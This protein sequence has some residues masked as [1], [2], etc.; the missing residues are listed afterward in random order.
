[1]L[2]LAAEMLCY[3]IRSHCLN[4][5]DIPKTQG[6]YNVKLYSESL[7]RT[8][9]VTWKLLNENKYQFSLCIPS[10]ILDPTRPLWCA[11]KRNWKRGRINH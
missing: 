7:D 5:Q 6:I 4:R 2:M 11:I 8:K 1:M 10:S 9:I 3:L